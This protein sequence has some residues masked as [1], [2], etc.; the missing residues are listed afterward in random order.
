MQSNCSYF[1]VHSFNPC[2][3]AYFLYFCFTTKVRIH[4][5]SI[6]TL[7]PLLV[8]VKL[9][10]LLYFSSE[11]K[12]KTGFKL[13]VSWVRERASLQSGLSTILKWNSYYNLEPMQM[14]SNK[15]PVSHRTIGSVSIS[16]HGSRTVSK[17][18]T[19]PS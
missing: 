18:F 14:E 13:N 7:L 2:F 19:V 9:L 5:S 4:I 6:Q 16:A 3:N 12:K 10:F 11:H 8:V 17:Y 15:N 1:T